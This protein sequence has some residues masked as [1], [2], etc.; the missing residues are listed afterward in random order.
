[1]DLAIAGRTALVTGASAGI[2]VG[3]AECLAREG[4]RLALAGRNAKALGEVARKVQSL[5][6]P[7]PVQITGDVATKAGANAVAQAAL[8]AFGG[9]RTDRG[10]GS[11]DG[12]EIRKAAQVLTGRE[13]TVILFGER[14]LRANGDE[15]LSA[16]W[17]L[18]LQTGS[19]FHPL[20][21]ENNSRGLLEVIGSKAKAPEEIFRLVSEGRVK[22]LFLTGPLVLPKK[23]KP[24]FLAVLDTHA[25]EILETADAVFPAAVPIEREPPE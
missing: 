23:F 25:S 17:N 1:M 18:A 2:G 13:P 16:L 20:G 14:F 24:E 8:E 12:A 9:G 7:A 19:A 21:L 15:N 5:G 10:S 6:A 4:V 22:A 3:I 11:E